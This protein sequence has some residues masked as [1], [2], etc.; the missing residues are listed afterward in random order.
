MGLIFTLSNYLKKH[1]SK[2]QVWISVKKHK[3]TEICEKIMM[4]DGWKNCPENKIFGF[5]SN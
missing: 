5:F 4:T 2:L 3:L 1:Q